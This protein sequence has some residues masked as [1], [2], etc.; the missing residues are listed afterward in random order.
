MPYRALYWRLIAALALAAP[1][2]AQTYP[3]KPV[4]M[5]VA[6]APGGIADISARLVSARLA[7]LWQIS[8]IV[9]NR[10]G[11]GGNIGAGIVAKAA[12]DGY[13]LIG[14]NFAT[15]GLN[16]VI[17]RKV[18]YDPIRDFTPVSMIGSA[19]NVLLVH[20]SVPAKTTAE[21]LAYARANPGKLSMGSS[22]GGTSQ[23]MTIELLKM[24]AGVNITPVPYQGGAPA[25]VDLLGGQIPSMVG[26]LPTVLPSIR[27]GRGRALGVTTA[28]RS[29]QAPDI[30]TLAESGVAGFDVASWN[31]VCGPAG[32]PPAVLAK[33][34]TD[35][36][37][38]LQAADIA[39]RLQEQG[40]D[41]EPMTPGRFAAHIQGEI[42]K[43]GK[44]VKATGMVLD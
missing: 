16:P 10:P 44:V 3:A 41:P 26:A 4:R 42:A 1:A 21:L 13:T 40:I 14:C 7:E 29:A 24:M 9:D 36:R 8:V 31:G 38:A 12:G 35:M 28:T 33:I 30:P 11:A 23:Y 43:W 34:S 22:A 37:R 32:L 39:K 15:H 17:Y 18:P 19:P 6:F 20:P 2:A 27:S 5:V 25:L